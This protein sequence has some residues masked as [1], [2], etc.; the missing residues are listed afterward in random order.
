MSSE[1]FI[2][3]N[4]EEFIDT[5]RALV[6][7]SFGK[8]ED[9]ESDFIDTLINIDPEDL[10]ELNDVLDYDECFAITFNMLKKQKN[11]KT[12]KIRYIVN[13]D[14]FYELIVALNS[15]MVSNILSKLTNKGLIESAFDEEQNDF[16]FWVK[17]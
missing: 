5:T 16:I 8:N 12:H 6:F 15:R 2:I 13:N 7:N 14:D 10:E 1:T 4:I 11:K 3:T 17:E 9:V